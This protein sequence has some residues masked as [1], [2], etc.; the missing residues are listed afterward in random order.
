MKQG[1][2]IVTWSGGK[3]QFECLFNSLEKP[4]KYGLLVVVNDGDN[5]GW[6][7]HGFDGYNG[8]YKVSYDGFELGALKLALEVTDWDEFI[9]LQDTFEIIDNKIF[10]ILFENY[11]DQSVSYGPER[12]MYLGKYRRQILKRLKIPDVREK[13]ESIYFESKFVNNYEEIEP[14]IIFNN[15]FSD[16]R[17]L[18]NYEWMW[19]RKNLILSDKYLIKRKG[20]WDLSNQM[21]KEFKEFN[22]KFQGKF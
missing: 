7:E 3:E 4:F 8:V 21:P 16:S 17:F 19:G 14:F 6:I 18:G 20:T 12:Q 15:D 22:E 13:V 1:V 2:I 9:L 10:Q 5:A 11:T